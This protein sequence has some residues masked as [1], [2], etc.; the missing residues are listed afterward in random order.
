[1]RCGRVL[2]IGVVVE[3]VAMLERVA[4]RRRPVGVRVHHV[5]VVV[6]VVYV[7]WR[8]DTCAA[9]CVVRRNGPKSPPEYLKRPSE[10]R[11]A[12]VSRELRH[13]VDFVV[14]KGASSRP[15]AFFE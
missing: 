15:W 9:K 11:P 13:D 2:A 4:R 12:T 8:L 3:L 7:F 5:M 14:D 1:M 6:V 10:Q